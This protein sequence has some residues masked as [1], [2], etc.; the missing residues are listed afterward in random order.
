MKNTGVGTRENKRPLP[1]DRLLSNLEEQLGFLVKSCRDFDRGDQSEVKRIAGVLRVLLY[2]RGTNKALLRQLGFLEDLAFVDT[3]IVF[4]ESNA[5]EVFGGKFFLP[6]SCWQGLLTLTENEDGST[7]WIAPLAERPHMNLPCFVTHSM[8]RYPEWWGK[9]FIASSSG[10]LFSRMDLVSIMVNQDGHAHCDPELDKDYDDLL[11]DYHGL[12]I[13]TG[14]SEE[15]FARPRGNIVYCSV[16][17]IA[18]ELMLSLDRR[19]GYDL[20]SRSS[21]SEAKRFGWMPFSPLGIIVE[22]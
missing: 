19:F 6:S 22:S 1:R 3:G 20:L 15:S 17:Q 8:T 16:R 7:E 9:R 12:E 2:E 18:F 4:D 21:N 5:A 11:A 13:S 10:T 14:G